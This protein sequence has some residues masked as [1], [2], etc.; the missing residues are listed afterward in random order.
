M[1][2]AREKKRQTKGPGNWKYSS[3]TGLISHWPQL[4]QVFP[5]VCPGEP[6]EGDKKD[7][8]PGR[9]SENTAPD[10]PGL[11]RWLSKSP[12]ET[13]A[14]SEDAVSC[15]WHSF[16]S[17]ISTQ[18]RPGDMNRRHTARY[19]ICVPPLK[20][21]FAFAT[22]LSAEHVTLW[23]RKE[24]RKEIFVSVDAKIKLCCPFTDQVPRILTDQVYRTCHAIINN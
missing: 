19:N 6:N 10:S 2:K 5:P 12:Q 11:C 18:R 24:R 17:H 22:H 15:D 14:Y 20:Q 3:D 13:A 21:T 16:V 23:Q 1:N 7:G 8:R 9:T 4:V